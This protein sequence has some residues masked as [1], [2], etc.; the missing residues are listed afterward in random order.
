MKYNH[1]PA[2]NVRLQI[3]YDSSNNFLKIR[4]FAVHK[5]LFPRSIHNSLQNYFRCISLMSFLPRPSE[6]FSSS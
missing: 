3:N 2:I 4:L 1:V 6:K 5:I